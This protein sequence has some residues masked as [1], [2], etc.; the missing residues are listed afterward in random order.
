MYVCMRVCLIEWVCLRAHTYM[1]VC[2]RVCVC[3][4]VYVCV[5]A[6]T[7][8]SCTRRSA[9]RMPLSAKHA[10][11]HMCMTI[12]CVCVCVYMLVCACAHKR[13]AGVHSSCVLKQAAPAKELLNS[14]AKQPYLFYY[15]WCVHRR[16]E[17]LKAKTLLL[18]TT[19]YPFPFLA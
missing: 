4:C 15:A 5:C 9:R 18:S 2:A 1:C 6:S 11:P 17:A 16:V 12:V 19:P 13:S 7:R 8:Q 14:R 10:Y 3:V